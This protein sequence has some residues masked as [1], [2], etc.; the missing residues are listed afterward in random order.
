MYKKIGFY[1]A[2]ALAI[3]PVFASAEALNRQLQVGS[4]GADVSV[5]Q[6]YLASDITLYP[7]GTVSG[8]YG[9]LTK[10]AVSNF[11]S[12][13]G[14]PAVGRVGPATLPVLNA[15]I[16]GGAVSS[17]V[18]PIIGGIGTNVNATSANI[19]WNTNEAATGVVYYSSSPLNVYEN[20]N[21]VTVNSA[22]TAMTDVTHKTSN[23]VVISGLQPNTTY[24]YMIYSTDQNGDVSVTWPSTFHT[25]S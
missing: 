19:L 24:Y 5:L 12:R 4:R 9:F 8:Y 6:T 22:A 11:Q 17:T 10:A 21:S 3:V 14:L 7:Q 18:A 23:S 1:V 15:R 20:T 13:N 25:K 16:A 2:I